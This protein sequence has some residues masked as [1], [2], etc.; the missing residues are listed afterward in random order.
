MVGQ[1]GWAKPPQ[2]TANTAKTRR[3]RQQVTSVSGRSTDRCPVCHIME[4]IQMSRE[5]GE[6]CVFLKNA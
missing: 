5:N 6:F 4:I 3:G 1:V 2:I